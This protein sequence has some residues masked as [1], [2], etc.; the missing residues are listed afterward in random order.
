MPTSLSSS[1]QMINQENSFPQSTIQTS[2]EDI[3]TNRQNENLSVKNMLDNSEQKK[4]E[5]KKLLKKYKTNSFLPLII[6][7]VSAN[8]NKEQ[9]IELIK[10]T[11]QKFVCYR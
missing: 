8:L 10:N 9:F 1:D 6:M 5:I 11:F 7:S 2:F 4:N 3:N